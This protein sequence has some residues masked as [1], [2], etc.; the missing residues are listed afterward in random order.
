MEPSSTKTRIACTS[1]VSD[2]EW[3]FCQP[4]LLLMNENAP[5]RL[6]LLRELYNALRYIVRCGCQWR[7]M[8]HDLPPWQAVY[9]QA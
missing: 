7:M 8:P 9:Q 1:D 2:E 5:Q 3:N 6:H 4:Y